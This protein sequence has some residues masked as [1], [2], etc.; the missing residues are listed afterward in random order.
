MM[1]PTAIVHISELNQT[2]TSDAEIRGSN[3]T[4][5]TISASIL[6]I[7]GLVGLSVLG[8][9]AFRATNSEQQPQN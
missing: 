3:L 6:I 4:A 5:V 1:K 7:V 8:F 2:F 9:Q